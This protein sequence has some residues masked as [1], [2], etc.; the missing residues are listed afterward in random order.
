M[1]KRTKSF[2]D[3]ALKRNRNF[4][5]S[6][7]VLPLGLTAIVVIILA[8]GWHIK[9]KPKQDITLINIP[10]GPPTNLT[11]NGQRWLL[12]QYDYHDDHD[13]DVL[14]HKGNIIG[15]TGAMTSC[16]ENKIWYDPFVSQALLRDDVWHEVNHAELCGED[17][18]KI[19]II[20]GIKLTHDHCIVYQL[21]MS[22]SSFI[23]DNP[24]FM[25]WMENWN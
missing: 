12:L 22:G 1:I 20:A 10:A 19:Q 9:P 6:E 18:V 3:K 16:S 14:D 23:H 25:K 2:A 24:E 11:I 21:G 7:V 13:F 15:H 17:D 8:I 5:L 4:A